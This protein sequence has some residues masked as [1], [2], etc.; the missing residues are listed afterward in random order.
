[1]PIEINDEYELSDDEVITQI[2]EWPGLARDEFME[3]LRL[4]FKR[5]GLEWPK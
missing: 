4:E 5:R 1:M 2:C 3:R